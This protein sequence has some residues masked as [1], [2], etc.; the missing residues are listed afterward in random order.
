MDDGRPTVLRAGKHAG[1]RW[2]RIT[3]KTWSSAIAPAVADDRV[4][5]RVCNVGEEPTP[6]VREWIKQIGVAA[7]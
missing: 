4:A 2:T 5:G 7:G 6:T 1:W 3:S